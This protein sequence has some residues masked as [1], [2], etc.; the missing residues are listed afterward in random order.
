MKLKL[1]VEKEFEVKYLQ[2]RV[3]AR[4]WEDST[5][6]GVEDEEGDLIPCRDGE[7]W[8]PLIDLETGIILNWEQGKVASIHYKS[9][10]DNEFI[11]LDE[12]K[13]HVKSIDGYVIDIMSPKEEGYGDYVIM[14]VLANGQI[15]EYKCDL[16]DFTA[17]TN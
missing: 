5:V 8:C 16:S 14:D 7:Y 1:K 12:N 9:C 10:D 13:N 6:D 4:Y 11:L 15:Q 2:A 3:G 17:D